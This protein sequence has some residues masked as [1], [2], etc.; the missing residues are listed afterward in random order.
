M[1]TDLVKSTHH[2]LNHDANAGEQYRVDRRQGVSLVMAYDPAMAAVLGK[3]RQ[4]ALTTADAVFKELKKRLQRSREGRVRGRPLTAEGALLSVHDYLTSHRLT[5][6]YHPE[7]T[8][9]HKLKV[10]ADTKARRWESLIDGKLIVETTLGELPPEE[11]IARYKE[12]TLIEQAFK[13]LKS[14]LQLRPMYH[15]TERRIRA[16]VFVCVIALQ[17]ERCMRLTLQDMKLSAHSAL[18]KLRQIKAGQILVN[19]LKTPMLSTATSEHKAIY[20]QLKIPFPTIN[21]VQNM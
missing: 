12:L 15:W 7:L 21:R 3:Q 6:Y 20:K 10:T 19:S 18:E 16:H 1:I 17:I 13:C 9:D 5:R 11:V 2:E 4:D 14:S 8:D